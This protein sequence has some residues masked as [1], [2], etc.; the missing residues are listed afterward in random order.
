MVGFSDH[1]IVFGMR[2]ISGNLKKEPKIIRSR[3]LKHYKPESFREDLATADWESLT[4]IED[5]GL[6]SLE[7]ERLFFKIL[8]RRNVRNNYASHINPE[9]RRKMFLRDHYK[10]KHHYTKSEND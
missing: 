10:K 7:W 5:I 1:D 4:E 2:K 3:Q 9:L 8:D 6:M